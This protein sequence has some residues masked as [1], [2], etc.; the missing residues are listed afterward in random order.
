M[1]GGHGAWVAALNS[2]DLYSN[3]LPESG[4]IRKEEYASFNAFFALDASNS[5]VDSEL[6]TVQE[7]AMA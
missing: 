2:P 6:K 5:F 3:L 7:L 4:W 1:G